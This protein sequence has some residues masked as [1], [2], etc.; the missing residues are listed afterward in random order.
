MKL[1]PMHFSVM[2]HAEGKNVYIAIREIQFLSSPGRIGLSHIG[3]IHTV[4]LNNK[5]FCS[6]LQNLI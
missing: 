3:Y 4:L 2:S 6:C 5:D 1:F